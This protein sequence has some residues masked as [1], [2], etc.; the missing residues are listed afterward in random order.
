MQ[1]DHEA[2]GFGVEDDFDEEQESLAA[3]DLY[4]ELR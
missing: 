2:D 1:S 4:P 3:E